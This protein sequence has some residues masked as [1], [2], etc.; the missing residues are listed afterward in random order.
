MRFKIFFNEQSRKLDINCLNDMHTD[1]I[2]PENPSQHLYFPIPNE[3]SNDIKKEL[4]PVLDGKGADAYHAITEEI[5][6][7]TDRRREMI[8]ELRMELNPKIMEI[9]EKFKQ[10][11]AE[12]FI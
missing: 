4:M 8:N 9:C 12:Y 1:T 11:N 5:Q 2:L 10:E 3:L 6:A 7:L